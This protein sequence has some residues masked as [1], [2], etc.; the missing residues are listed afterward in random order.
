MGVCMSESYQIPQ[1]VSSLSFWNLA[2][3]LD[4]LADQEFDLQLLRLAG[5]VVFTAK[6]DFDHSSAV[7]G[8]GGVRDGF[9]IE[10]GV[11]AP[12]F[13]YGVRWVSGHSDML[14][15]RRGAR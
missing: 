8:E 7:R 10:V 9:K 1:S 14:S 3:P 6:P 12:R 4:L 13:T 15:S 11:S 5:T 2:V